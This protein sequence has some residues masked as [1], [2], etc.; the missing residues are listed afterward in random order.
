M[1]KLYNV[2]NKHALLLAILSLLLSLLLFFPTGYVAVDEYDYLRGS[3]L[4][5]QGE[6]RQ[7]C[8]PQVWSQFVT[9][10]G[11]C[12]SKYNVG[13]SLFLLPAAINNS[14]LLPFVIIWGTFL[15]GIIF[16]AKILQL[17]AIPK[18]YTLLYAF[19]PA[20]V[21]FSRTLYSE[22]ISATLFTILIYLVI[23]RQRKAN[24]SQ[25][26]TLINVAIGALAGIAVIVRYTNALPIAVMLL[27]ATV[28]LVRPATQNIKS[29]KQYLKT[30]TTQLAQHFTAII[31]GGLPFLGF[32]LWFNSYLYGSPLRSGYHYAAE[33]LVF[34]WQSFPQHFVGYIAVMSMVYPG[35]LIVGIA[36]KNY[37]RSILML[38]V[39]VSVMFYSLFPISLFKGQPL[40]LITGIR[41]IIPVMPALILL[42]A[43]ALMQLKKSSRLYYPV[44]VLVL[45]LIIGASFVLAYIHQEFLST[46]GLSWPQMPPQ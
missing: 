3:Y 14:N 39:L 31:L 22:T 13:T 16:F 21:Y 44:L 11:Y 38:P 30:F 6:L 19:F 42:Y 26:S 23:L 34:S 15:V 37:W 45:L 8:D 28:M 12:I 29:S 36:V 18:I 46:R 43:L 20:F 33:E 27:L 41:F 7:E 9:P 2:L 10:E 35:M 5:T 1:I 40:D 25:T 4:I 17:L 24:D 32:L